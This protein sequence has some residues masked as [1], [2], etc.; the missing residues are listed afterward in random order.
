MHKYKFFSKL[1]LRALFY[2]RIN[3]IVALLAIILGTSVIGGLVNIYYNIN[4]KM[5]KE[6]RAYGAN[7]LIYPK[8]QF[9]KIKMDK[10]K[11]INR[12]IPNS[13]VVGMAPMQYSVVQI[14]DKS[15]VLVG[16]WLDQMKNVSPY[17]SIDG[18][19]ISDRNNLKEAMIG[20][21]VAKKYNIKQGSAIEISNQSKRK[22]SI[23]VKG[24]VSSGGKEDNQ[25]FVN[26]GLAEKISKKKTADIILVSLLEKGSKLAKESSKLQTSISEINVKPI[27]Q[28]EQSEE[29]MLVKIQRLIRLIGIIIFVIT[30][31]TVSTTMISMINE[32]RKEVGLKKAL[33]ASNKLLLLEFLAEGTY[34]SLIGSTFGIIAA[35]YLSQLIGKS[36]FDAEISF[37]YNII[38]WTYMI[39]LFIVAISF[40][41]PVRK[42]MEVD[43]ANTLKGN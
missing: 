39:A 7:I 13:K 33:G 14:E 26:T 19:W 15:V 17:W 43:P 35:F 37:Q 29:K 22:F 32:R 42:I 36:V 31:L 3:T 11:E 10:V 6:F 25:I 28:M 9:V 30:I 4:E 8:D 12:N 34:I 18:A 5:S 24:I 27:K 23:K 40:F 20:V 41:I 21:N 1:V 38:P 16:T 2:R